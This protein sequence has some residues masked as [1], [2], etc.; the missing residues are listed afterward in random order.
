MNVIKKT[1]QE[2]GRYQLSFYCPGC[3]E[4]HNVNET[5]HWNGN[6]DKPT[7]QPS[8]RVRA[9]HGEKQQMRVCHS[10]ITEGT[11]QFLHDCTHDLSG[12]TVALPNIE[13]WLKK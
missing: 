1:E 3:R 5:W 10:Y 6:L 12:K 9:P 4:L 11:I 13:P 2:H 7:I 8:I